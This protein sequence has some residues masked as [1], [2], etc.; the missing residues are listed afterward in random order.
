MENGL[1]AFRTEIEKREQAFASLLPQSIPVDKFKTVL[2]AA[3]TKVPSLLSADRASLMQACM[4]CARYGLL[5]DGNDAALTTFKDFKSGRLLVQLLVMIKGILRRA[6]ELGDLSSISA[7][8]VHEGD[9]FSIELGDEPKI[10]HMLAVANRG[11]V[12][13]AYAIFRRGEEVIHREFMTRAEIDQTRGVS[14]AK[15]GD[16]WTKWFGEMARK[17]VVRR[18]SKSIPMSDALAEIVSHE[19]RY[20]DF[21]LADQNREPPRVLDAKAL[22][23]GA[24]APGLLDQLEHKLSGAHTVEDINKVLGEFS[25]HVEASQDEDEKTKCRQLAKKHLSRVK[26]AAA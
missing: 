4:D 7:Y 10:V 1:V 11:D 5:P 24:P 2:L 19:D 8:T 17:T 15:A 6:R 16:A 12:I 13:A 14:R 18:G 3:A 20:T 22:A 21:S 23:D 25:P 26:S 9:V